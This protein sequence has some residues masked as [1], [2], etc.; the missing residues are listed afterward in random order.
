LVAEVDLH[1]APRAAIED[2]LANRA[3][4]PRRRGEAR[5]GGRGRRYSRYTSEEY[6]RW[7]LELE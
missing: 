1:R 7:M 5:R 2:Y 3:R 6:H 4:Q